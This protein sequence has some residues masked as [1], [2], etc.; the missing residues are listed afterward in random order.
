MSIQPLTDA[1]LGFIGSTP[2]PFHA[3]ANLLHILKKAGFTVLNEN[4]KWQISEAGKYAVLR[5][6]SLIA[7]TSGEDNFPLFFRQSCRGRDHRV[8]PADQM[9]DS[10]IRHVAAPAHQ[11]SAPSIRVPPYPAM[12]YHRSTPKR[13]PSGPKTK[14]PAPRSD[15][16]QWYSVRLFVVGMFGPGTMVSQVVTVIT[17]KYNDSAARQFQ[18]ING[19]QDPSDLGVHVT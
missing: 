6:G 5:N 17:P 16:D 9:V 10:G 3:A 15:N 19:I 2:T 14:P 4:E 12:P 8:R 7:F 1:L 18:C 13:G 11:G